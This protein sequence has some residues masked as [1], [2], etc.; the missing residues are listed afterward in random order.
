MRVAIPAALLLLLLLALSCG[1]GVGEGFPEKDA[2]D[3]LDTDADSDSDTDTDTSTSIQEWHDCPSEIDSDCEVGQ[4]GLEPLLAADE[5]GPEISF[6]AMGRNAL[7]A[8]RTIDT[9]V[10]PLIVWMDFD[11]YEGID[12]LGL[13]TL[14]TPPLTSID[15]LA[16]AGDLDQDVFGFEAMAL[17]EEDDGPTLL[18][19]NVQLAE[20]GD[21]VPVPNGDVP[22]TAE[23]RGLVYVQQKVPQ[24]DPQYNL[25]CAYGDGIFC[26]DGAEW[27]TELPAGIGGPINDVG[28]LQVDERRMLVVGD[29][30]FLARDSAS[31][32]IE[33][34]SGTASDLLALSVDDEHFLAAGR[35]GAHVW[36]SA[37]E[38]WSC[39]VGN[40]T[41]VTLS[42]VPDEGVSCVL[43]SGPITYWTFG[44][45]EYGP[46][47]CDTGAE[48][49][50]VLDSRIVGCDASLN[51]F[52]L[53]AQ[54]LFGG[55]ECVAVE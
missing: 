1:P 22:T 8:A 38:T 9:V 18:G 21:L 14:P 48:L 7:L 25:V 55:H 47:L 33:L 28:M 36:G 6:V 16:I 24:Q 23:L 39:P 2:G 26:F 45:D 46:K 44:L 34:V 40:G 43:D 37:A 3:G 30:G 15:P 10:E 5:I 51:L 27:T 49:S 41:A 20:T 54:G 11:E 12:S 31:G 50:G 4:P 53:T 13:A 35:D 29:G 17:V 42:G 19:S 32:W 52:L